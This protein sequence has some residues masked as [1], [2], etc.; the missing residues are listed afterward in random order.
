MKYGLKPHYNLLSASVSPDPYLQLQ[1][2]QILYT[3]GT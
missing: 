2:T 3:A 1:R